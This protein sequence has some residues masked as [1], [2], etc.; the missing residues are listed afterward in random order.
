[1]QVYYEK[2]EHA[3]SLKM[4]R[5]FVKPFLHRPSDMFG[6]EEDRDY[7]EEFGI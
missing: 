7:S 3:G 5:T 6:T 1:M 4:V 2:Q